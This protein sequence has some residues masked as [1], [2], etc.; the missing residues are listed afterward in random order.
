MRRNL[1]INFFNTLSNSLPVSLNLVVALTE[2]IRLWKFQRNFGNLI[3]LWRQTT[4][5]YPDEKY[6]ILVS[7]VTKERRSLVSFTDFWRE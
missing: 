7:M 6:R 1:K 5:F 2:L 4:G 3:A